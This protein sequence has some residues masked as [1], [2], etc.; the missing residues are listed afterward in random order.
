VLVAAKGFVVS[1]PCCPVLLLLLIIM[2]LSVVV[3]QKSVL[4]LLLVL[5][6]LLLCR[7]SRLLCLVH[8]IN[9]FVHGIN[10]RFQVP[11]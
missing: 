4:L 8:C 1:V 2:L 10:I 3:Q 9:E 7:R 5:G 11:I 6:G